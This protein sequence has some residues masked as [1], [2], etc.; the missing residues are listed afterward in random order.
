[1]RIPILSGVFTDRGPNVRA[2]YPVNLVPVPGDSG[3]SDAY[4]RPADGIVGMSVGPGVTRGGLNWLGVWHLVMGTSLVSVDAEGSVFILG[5]V[6]AGGTVSMC[7]GPRSPAYP[8]GIL[9]IASGGRLYYWDGS[10]L[11]QVTDPDL[12]VCLDVVWIDGYFMST[13]GDSIVVSELANPFA[14]D[15]LKY[16][17]SEA[18]PDPIVALVRVRNEIVAL[19]RFTCEVFDNVGGSGFPFQRIEGA[20]IQ[21]GCIGTHACCVFLEAVA[22]LGSGENEAPG[23]YLGSNANAAKLSTIEI[24][25]VLAGFSEL[26]LSTVLI[27]TRNDN[28]HLHLYV[29]LPD[30]TLVY[31]HTASQA[32]SQPVWFVLVSGLVGFQAYRGRHFTWCYDRWLSGDATG[33]FLGEFSQAT[34]QVFSERTRWEMQTA[35][36]YNAGAGALVNQLE[37]VALTG[38]IDDRA[39]ISADPLI[40]TSS[41]LDGVTWSPDVSV[42]AGR[43]GQF[44]NRLVWFRQGALRNMRIQRFQGDSDAHVSFLRLEAAVE[45]LVW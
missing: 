2:S 20:Q 26:Q 37:L 21:K 9:A 40:A 44:L 4:L 34:G 18:S 8:I 45:R 33:D 39:D 13:D 15:P 17:S 35:I 43:S 41:S 10:T 22:F 29:H 23:I 28:G 3:V 12:G 5:D 25:R 11:T 6:G 30:R 1:M 27:E 31:D 24:D 32:L 42:P 19:N 38:R 14:F 16:G 7:Y 36:T